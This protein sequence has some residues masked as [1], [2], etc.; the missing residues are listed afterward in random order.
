MCRFVV[1]LWGLGVLFATTD[2]RA[3]NA[4]IGCPSGMNPCGAID[5]CA[6]GETCCSS[7]NGAQSQCCST[8]NQHCCASSM[9]QNAICAF[10]NMQE[11]CGESTCSTANSRCINQNGQYTPPSCCPNSQMVC[12]QQNGPQWCCTPYAVGCSGDIGNICCDTKVC[13]IN[14][15]QLG[16]CCMSP[17]AQC[18]S[19]GNG[20]C[21]PPFHVCRDAGGQPT[22]CC[23]SGNK[24]SPFGTCTPDTPQHTSQ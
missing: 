8:G 16:S 22:A 21:E 12:Q 4:T 3:L 9:F 18:W 10:N 5:C 20:C 13:K 7:P 1:V 24:C 23:V 17:E 11:C 15:E 2:I 14:P 6:K 19:G